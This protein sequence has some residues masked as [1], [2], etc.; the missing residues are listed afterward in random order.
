MIIGGVAL[1]LVI[2]ASLWL[3]TG[4]FTP[5]VEASDPGDTTAE[6]TPAPADNDRDAPAPADEPESPGTSTSFIDSL[7]STEI[8]S[9]GD[10]VYVD[11]RDST[12]FFTFTPGWDDVWVIRTYDNGDDDPL[13]RIFDANGNWIA[14]DDDNAGDRNAILILYLN[15]GET[16]V[17]EADYWG[18]GGD[19]MLAVYYAEEI[20]SDGGVINIDGVTGFS[21]VPDESGTWEFYTSNNGNYDPQLYIKDKNGNTLANDDDSGDNNNA[22]LT[23]NLS[24]GETYVVIATLWLNPHDGNFDLTVNKQ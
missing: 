17:I 6:V 21:F 10:S 1:I 2:F 12:Q 24:A 3:F 19:Y 4:I 9:S 15:G 11:V 7:D 5:K 14:E 13:I 22:Y 16:Y 23:V 20:P 18:Q 8:S